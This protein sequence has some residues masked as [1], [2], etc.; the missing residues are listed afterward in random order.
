MGD[1]DI[2]ILL[3]M[4]FWVTVSP[5]I[6][7]NKMWSCEIYKKNKKSWIIEE[8]NSFKTPNKCYDWALSILTINY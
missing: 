4:G 7:N 5:S 6:L 8:T 2:D 3:K 1:Y